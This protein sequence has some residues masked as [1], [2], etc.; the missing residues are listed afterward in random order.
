MKIHFFQILT[1]AGWFYSDMHLVLQKLISDTIKSGQKISIEMAKPIFSVLIQQT[2]Q[3]RTCLFDLAL[4]F[5]EQYDQ[6]LFHFS[7]RS[8]QIWA[9]WTEGGSWRQE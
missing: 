5:K 9:I 3:I 2:R 7:L 8:A 1:S 6:G 4:K